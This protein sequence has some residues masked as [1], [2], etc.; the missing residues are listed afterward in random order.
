[1]KKA[2]LVRLAVCLT[3]MLVP[4]FFVGRPQLSAGGRTVAN[5]RCVFVPMVRGSG[6][7]TANA[8]PA[9]AS[10]NPCEQVVPTTTPTRTTAPVTAT[11][12]RTPT[13][14]PPSQLSGAVRL[15]PVAAGSMPENSPKRY[16]VVLDTSGSMSANVEGQ[17]NNRGPTIQC[18]EGPNGQANITETGKLVW[19]NP[20]SERRI[21]VAK[22]SLS[23]LI[24]QLNMVGN[25]GYTLARPPDQFGLVWFNHEQ[26]ISMTTGFSSHP[27]ELKAALVDAG[28]YDNDPYR[29]LGGTNG[30]GGMYRAR[31]LLDATPQTV[32]YHGQTYTYT[33]QIIY[34]TDG[35]A[36]D[37]LDPT[38]ANLAGGPSDDSTYPAGSFCAQL[39]AQV[40][41]NADCQSNDGG[42]LYNDWDRPITQLV[43]QSTLIKDNPVSNAKVFVIAI[44]NISSAGLRDGV[45]SFPSYYYQ[46]ITLVR[47]PD[48]STNLDRIIGSLYDRTTPE[49]CQPIVSPFTNL[50]TSAQLPVGVPG[51]G[52]NKVGELR[53]TN[54]TTGEIHTFDLAVNAATSELSYAVNGL[55]AG[56]YELSAY[57]FYRGSDG[58]TREYSRLYTNE[59]STESIVLELGPDPQLRNLDLLLNGNVCATE[60]VTQ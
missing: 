58:V 13:S 10:G 2:S 31:Q 5:Q 49:N 37:F 50:I 8:S 21:A 41:R 51:L 38:K 30:A 48:G 6:G 28:S 9:P 7:A 44:S 1:M 11:P 59:S 32:V 22:D 25:S 19:W 15:R 60:Y 46:M 24:D 27:V 55:P 16:L 56:E 12:T 3:I 42:G 47:Y 57:I 29:T 20:P 14:G 39:G 40:L 34:I 26:A 52:G 36:S 23:Y 53:L 43:K 45:A 35:V 33:Q 4:L 54:I 18:E 17:C